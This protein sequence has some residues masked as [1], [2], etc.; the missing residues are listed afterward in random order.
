VHGDVGRA[1]AIGTEEDAVLKFIVPDP[2]VG[3]SLDA[4]H[5]DDRLPVTLVDVEDVSPVRRHFPFGRD[6]PQR[7]LF[8]DER[9][10]YPGHRAT[11]EGKHEGN[12]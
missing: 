4:V 9:H 3:L 12:R 5:H 1:P 8:R 2:V 10:V 7:R 11:T 6:L